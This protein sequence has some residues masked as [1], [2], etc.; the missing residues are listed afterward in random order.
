MQ[1]GSN[2][3]KNCLNLSHLKN[4]NKR[5]RNL[6]TSYVKKKKKKKKMSNPACFKVLLYLSTC[7]STSHIDHVTIKILTIN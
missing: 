5:L 1:Y 3:V 7:A 4:K 2:I 6:A